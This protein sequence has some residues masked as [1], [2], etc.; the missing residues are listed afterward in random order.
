MAR[1]GLVLVVNTEDGVFK[2]SMLL[3]MMSK[4]SVLE[5]VKQ[6]RV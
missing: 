4:T 5:Q 1:A 6:E 3:S 2:E